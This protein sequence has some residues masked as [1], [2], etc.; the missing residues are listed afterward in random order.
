MYT[1]EDVCA[2]ITTFRPEE[3]LEQ[4]VA[5]VVEQVSYVIVVDDTGDA[6]QSVP[7][8]ARVEYIANPE[9][10]GI[11]HSLNAGIELAIAKGFSWILTLDDDTRITEDY[12]EKLLEFCNQSRDLKLNLGV[13]ALSRHNAL[14]Q[15]RKPSERFRHKNALI[16]SGSLCCSKA[17]DAVGGFNDKLFI[18]LVDI[19]FCT[20]LR[21]YGFDVV[22]VMI[23]GMEHDVGNLMI[24]HIFG[25][26]VNVYNHEPFRLYYQVRNAIYYFCKYVW[27]RPILSLYVLLD[28]ARVPLKAV[29]FEADKRRRLQYVLRGLRDGCVFKL[30]RIDTG[31]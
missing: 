8:K 20:R 31:T 25:I 12:V 29:L 4:L 6:R 22:Q 9:N 19:E 18:D 7:R 15:T 26:R 30:G 1:I 17:I 10:L 3:Q 23:P 13:V 14:Q 11:A 24:R 5:A 2:V 28:V 16:T 27:T 21:Q